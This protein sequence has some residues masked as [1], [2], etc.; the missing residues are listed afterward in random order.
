MFILPLLFQ[1]VLI[2]FSVAFH[3]RDIVASVCWKA[4]CTSEALLPRLD[5]Y[6]ASTGDEGKLG[7]L[8]G[9]PPDGVSEVP[10]SV[11]PLRFCVEDIV[12]TLKL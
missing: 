10:K 12:Q 7:Q 1:D 4:I 3:F 11:W 2:S 5:A 9:Y 8:I 6:L